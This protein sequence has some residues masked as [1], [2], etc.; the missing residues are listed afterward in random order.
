MKSEDKRWYDCL[1]TTLQQF[2]LLGIPIAV[3][4]NKE[5]EF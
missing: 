3:Y 4:F 2:D 5:R 1:A